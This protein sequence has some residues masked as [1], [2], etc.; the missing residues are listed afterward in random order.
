M[1][2]YDEISCIWTRLLSFCDFVLVTLTKNMRMDVNKKSEASTR[3]MIH[4]H[5][6]IRRVFFY[7][8][9]SYL[10]SFFKF[11]RNLLRN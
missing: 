7:M 5:T 2:K 6:Y 11:F 4:G 8:Y 1:S 10:R 9:E 3:C